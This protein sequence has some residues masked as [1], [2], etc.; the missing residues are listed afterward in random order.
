MDRFYRATMKIGGG[1]LFGRLAFTFLLVC[2]IA[3]G[4][5]VGLLFVYTSDLPEIR[6]L[7]NYRPNTVTEV[8][9]D[10]GQ[11]IGT[12]AQQ[13][14][15]LVTYSQIP[16]MLRDAILTTED[17]HFEEHIGVDIPR[18]LEAA[19]SDI[20][21]HSYREGA[22]TLTMQLAGGLFLNRN[23]RSLH[24]K[25]QETILAIQIER[26]YTK[27][28]IFTMYCNQVYL[29]N[30][31]YGFESASEYYFGKPALQVT[32][33]EAALLAAMIRGPIYSPTAHPKAALAR[34]NLVLELMYR[35]GKISRV[36]EEA[37]VKEPME[38]HISVPRD[39]LAPYFVEDI[40]EYLEHTYGTAAVHEQG[41]R[42]YTTLNV[43]MQR[44][45]DQAVRDGLHAYD[46]R[47][48][49]RGNLTN[50]FAQ[51]LGTLETYQNDDWRVPIE[52]GDYVT[53]LVTNVQPTF[54]MIKLG[55]VHAMLTP[56]D[57][58]WTGK[59]S[60]GQLLKVGDLVVVDIKE[61]SGNTA[62]VQ[63]EQEPAAQAALLAIDNSTGEIKA[64][65]GG[66][67]FEESKFNRAT[68]AM[69]QTGSSFKV[70]VYSQALL[71]GMNPF[72]T[73][74]DEP[75]T[76]ISGGKPYSPKNYDERFEGRITLRRALAD[77]RN[78]PAVRLLDHVGIEN[79]IEL[80][81]K[82]GLTSPLPPYLPL[83]LGAA[84]LTL[85]EH[86]SAFTVFPDDGIHILPHDIRKV[87]TYDG[88]L[89]EEA[90]PQVTD[91][92]PPDV[93]RTMVAMLEDVV[94][95]GTGVRA[96]EL[97]RPSAGKT[98]TTNDFTDAWYIGF[99]PQL[100]CGVWVGND[101]K[102]ISLGKKETGA[103]VALPIWLE[104]MQKAMVG[105]P[106]ENFPN[107]VPLEKIAPTQH[108]LV[109]V[110]DTAPPA[111]AAEQGLTGAAAG[112]APAPKPG[113]NPASSPAQ[114][115]QKSNKPP[116]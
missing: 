82:F 80:A 83:A 67:D 63:L 68:Q 97:G 98:G 94:Q 10:D 50:I 99:T 13:R 111:D 90:R 24:R 69:R 113:E 75:V 51:H 110:P 88:A 87:T 15:I 32:L 21:H 37:A 73:V 5:A 41:L 55:T 71:D 4:A 34:R 112:K 33:P 1:T 62:E 16:K 25:I 76:Y 105:M 86:T 77:S 64:M 28:Q 52:K 38:L 85:I 47:H 65:V 36:Q 96:K 7:E 29:W 60:P 104:F 79:V 70:Y 27:E 48:G 39:D 40:R 106:V 116:A 2:A 49:W 81:R 102:R 3:F 35:E 8:Y 114:Q 56:A 45:A 100:T 20:R 59:T 109:D 66:Y 12:F 14:R 44:A 43:A 30:G 19:W 58:A 18:V 84:D 115:Q 95:F 31:N 46:R 17:Q 53:G 61:L 93:A 72:D 108:V 101:D 42:V 23:D 6:A 103:R 54:A 91:V 9:A 74:V 11:L 92:I 107:V 57:F 78:V 22:S 26:H 89:L